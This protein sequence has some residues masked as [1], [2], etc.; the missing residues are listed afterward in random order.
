MIAFGEGKERFLLIGVLMV[1]LGLTASGHGQP[2][3]PNWS[4]GFH[5]QG[6][7]DIVRT[8]IAFDDGSGSAVYAG[9][10][11]TEAGGATVGHLARWDGVH[12]RALGTGMDNDV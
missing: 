10:D 9:G 12:W 5:L 8:M 1:I 11:F 6:M 3:N 2:C 7:N 4:T